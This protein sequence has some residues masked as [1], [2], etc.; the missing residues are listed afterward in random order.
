[1]YV[2]EHIQ[3][4]LD[5]QLMDNKKRKPTTI[6]KLSLLIH[7]L[8]R[9]SLNRNRQL[10]TQNTQEQFNSMFQQPDETAPF[11]STARDPAGN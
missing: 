5:F 6:I 2:Q 7:S 1:M 9:C 8:K 4:K 10:H 3:H 11:I